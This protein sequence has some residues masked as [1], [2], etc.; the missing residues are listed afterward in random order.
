[1]EKKKISLEDISK[2]CNVRVYEAKE[3]N[4]NLEF[5][6]GDIVTFEL[7]GKSY[8]N[9]VTDVGPDGVKMEPIVE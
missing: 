2:N 5:K 9:R 6:V 4:P 3:E 7:E 8:T 1:M